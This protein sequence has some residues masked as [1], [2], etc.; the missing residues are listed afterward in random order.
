VL[1][2]IEVYE[3]SKGIKEMI[4]GQEEDQKPE[5]I[6]NLRVKFNVE[7][8]TFKRSKKGQTVC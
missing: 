6:A 1:N 4:R 3:L 7:Q 5:K 8:T 2:P